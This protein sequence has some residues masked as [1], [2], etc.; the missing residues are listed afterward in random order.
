MELSALFP[1]FGGTVVAFLLYMLMRKRIR[2]HS[3][4]WDVIIFAAIFT[5]VAISI[6]LS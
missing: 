2:G 6:M 3:V 5:G 4:A 1:Y